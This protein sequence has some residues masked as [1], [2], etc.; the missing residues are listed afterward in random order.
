MVGYFFG[1]FLTLNKDAISD[2]TWYQ[3]VR[4]DVKC[5]GVQTV[6]SVT[7]IKLLECIMLICYD[8]IT[9]ATAVSRSQ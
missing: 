8:N 3:N 6:G 2:G 5:C 1:C 4:A 7:R 9:V